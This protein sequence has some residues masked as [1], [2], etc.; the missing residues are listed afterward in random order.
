MLAPLG[1]LQVYATPEQQV[2]E[3]RDELR[4]VT[5]MVKKAGLTKQ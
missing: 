2:A 4:R 3:A 1:I 5:E